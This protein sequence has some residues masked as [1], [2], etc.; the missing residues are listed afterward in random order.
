MKILFCSPNPLDRKLGAPKVLIELA[1][2]MTKLGCECTLVSD[3]DT[4]P[5]IDQYQGL[6]KNLMYMEALRDFL[7]RESANFDVVDY[8]HRYLPYSRNLF[9]KKPLFVARSVMLFQHLE[10]IKFPRFSG[11]RSWI[12][13]LT[14]EPS[15]RKEQKTMI[16]YCDQTCK[17]ADLINVSNDYDKVELIRRGFEADKILVVPYGLTESRFS[18]FK[19]IGLQIP[20]QPRVAFVGTFDVRKGAK[21][22]P[23]IFQIVL[24]NI[25]QVKFRLIGARYRSPDEILN[26]FPKNLHSAIELVTHFEPEE[27]PSILNE[28]SVGIF[29][30]YLE[31]FGFGVL[32]MLAAAIPVIG[33]DAPG[34]PMMLTNEYL[35][36]SGD[37]RAMAEKV[38]HLLKDKEK[39]S[40]SRAWAKTRAQDFPWSRA[41]K[42]TFEAYGARL[43]QK[44]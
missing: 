38:V 42:I 25:P 10:R 18:V 27:L 6:G 16:G 32:E 14:K 29:P 5:E 7:K 17:E 41:A 8:E 13:F 33:Y 44:N 24:K 30:S 21:E 3:K 11:L 2:E 28:C 23:E 43:A 36:P 12:G 35:V 20:P 15:R 40:I 9:P 39:L 19:N 22:F 1:E 34:V 26:H 4:C 37:A 31:G